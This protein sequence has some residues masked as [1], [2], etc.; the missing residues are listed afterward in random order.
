[1][2]ASP[3]PLDPRLTMSLLATKTTRS[4]RPL[5]G[6]FGTSTAVAVLTALLGA[7]SDATAPTART[8]LAPRETPSQ[9]VYA[10][11]DTTVTRFTYNPLLALEQ[12][13]AGGHRVS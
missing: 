8:E 5:L 11:G 1:M 6:W 2:P 3:T 4:A 12:S 13:F 7:C 9:T 10:V